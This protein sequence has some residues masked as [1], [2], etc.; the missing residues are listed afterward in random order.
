MKKH[1]DRPAE[2]LLLKEIQ[3]LGQTEGVNRVFTTFLELMATGLAAEMDTINQEERKK[4]YEELEAK[5]DTSQIHVYG[6]MCMLMVRAALI[7]AM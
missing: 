1:I 5:M 2:E 6:K 7:K 3:M 4:R